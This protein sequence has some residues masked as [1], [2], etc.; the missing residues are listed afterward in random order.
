MERGEPSPSA[1]HELPE[2]GEERR[3]VTTL[4]CDLVGFTAI[5]ERNNP[6]LVDVMLRRYYA[7]ARRVIES[8]GGTVEKYIGD[9]VVAAFGVPTLH[10]DDPERAVR[11]GL[12]LVDEIDALPGI[13]GERIEARIGVNTGDVLVRLDVDPASGEGFLT[14]DAVDVGRPSAECSAADGG[15]RRRGHSHSN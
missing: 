8:Y 13:G 14:G 15:R 7:A 10:E 1:G 4:F 6:E 12:R 2:R 11:A 5:S 3:V 9:A